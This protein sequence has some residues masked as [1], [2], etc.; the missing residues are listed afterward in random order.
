MALPECVCSIADG[1]Y[2]SVPSPLG[3]I[4]SMT[5]GSEVEWGAYF[6]HTPLIA[7][8][9]HTAYVAKGRSV[10]AEGSS[11]PLLFPSSLLLEKAEVLLLRASLPSHFH[12]QLSEL[13]FNEIIGS[14]NFFHTFSVY[15]STSISNYILVNRICITLRLLW[16]SL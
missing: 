13:E 10:D 16:K 8:M 12:L 11:P 14:G 1:S 9:T 6:S 4:K 3:K 2:V 15:I 5:K 7:E